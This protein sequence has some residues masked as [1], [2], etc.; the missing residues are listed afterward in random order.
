MSIVTPTFSLDAQPEVFFSTAAT[1]D[2]A[3]YAVQTDRA[4]RL[5]PRLYT[6]S[7]SGTPE[8]ICRRNWAAVAAGYFPEAVITSR[9]AFAFKPT[10]TPTGRS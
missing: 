1:N 4:R 5:G 2:A 9:S 8:D 7:M 3:A 6:R 10:P